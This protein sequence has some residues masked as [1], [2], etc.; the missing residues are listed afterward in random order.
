MTNRWPG[1]G[2]DIGPVSEPGTDEC[3]LCDLAHIL[4]A[5]SFLVLDAL[6]ECRLCPG[7]LRAK[8][9]SGTLRQVQ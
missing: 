2:E 9:S 8:F 1:Q 4:V 5:E 6:V 3:G 7:W